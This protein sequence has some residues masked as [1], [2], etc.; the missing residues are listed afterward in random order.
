MLRQKLS[1]KHVHE[2]KPC[3]CQDRNG[4]QYAFVAE[5]ESPDDR[6]YYV[7]KDPTHQSFVKTAEQI[8]EKAIVV[9]YTAG[10]F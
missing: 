1:K 7:A 10:V 5:F 3:Q 4:I 2:K 6:D 8:I 9:D